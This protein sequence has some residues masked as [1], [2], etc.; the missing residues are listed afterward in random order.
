MPRSLKQSYG[1]IPKIIYGTGS[2]TLPSYPKSISGARASS[3]HV[4]G[5]LVVKVLN[6][7]V[8]IIRQIEC[9]R[10]GSF[11]H[12]LTKYLPNGKV[13]KL[14]SVPGISLGDSHF[15]EHDKK[16][17]KATLEIIKFFNPKNI[18][19][20]DVFSGNS[21]SHHVHSKVLSKFALNLNLK[22]EFELGSRL[23]KTI[24]NASSK[25][26]N[27]YIIKSN[28][29]EHLMRYFEES[30]FALD[31]SN[32]SFAVALLYQFFNGKDP[33]E[34]GYRYFHN[35]KNVTFLQ[36]HDSITIEGIDISNHG[37]EGC[38]W[39]TW[40]PKVYWEDIWQQSYNWPP[41]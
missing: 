22:D 41:A 31:Y 30:R 36:R 27:H 12:D 1:Y 38:L 13:K 10:D 39:Q 37:D 4:N 11:Y 3:L 29:C 15:G 14:K 35:F 34:V 21:I 32:L 2:L 20:H 8:S 23:L 40:F 25:T 19:Y 18:A 5:A 26:T 6:N 9:D 33:I 24:I 17:F 7:K 28:H 16:A